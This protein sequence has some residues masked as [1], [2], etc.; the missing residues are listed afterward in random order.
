MLKSLGM[1]HGTKNT[2]MFY[3]YR[4]NEIKM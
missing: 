3:T 4:C 2:G 1:L